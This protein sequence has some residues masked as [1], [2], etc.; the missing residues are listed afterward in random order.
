MNENSILPGFLL[1]N[2]I[3]WTAKIMPL[4]ENMKGKEGGKD[5]YGD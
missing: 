3:V 4:R 5:I 2:G 1:Y